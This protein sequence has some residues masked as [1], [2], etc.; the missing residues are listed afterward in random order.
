MKTK[1]TAQGFNTEALK[2]MSDSELADLGLAA[3]FTSLR[4]KLNSDK[5]SDKLTPEEKKKINA[6]RTDWLQEA[7]G[8]ISSQLAWLYSVDGSDRYI[9]ELKFQTVD[10]GVMY[11]ALPVIKP[12]KIGTGESS[13]DYYNKT[14]LKIHFYDKNYTP[15]PDLLHMQDLITGGVINPGHGMTESVGSEDTP[16]DLVANLSTTQIK[17]IIK[18]RKS[19]FT[20]GAEYTNVESF[21]IQSVGTGGS[22]IG[23]ALFLTALNNKD[24]PQLGHGGVG[25]NDDMM[26]I[27]SKADVKCLGMPFLVR[28]QELYV[29]MNSGTTADNMYI[30]TNVKHSIKDNFT[31]TFALTYVGANSI[32]DV[33]K[34]MINAVDLIED[35]L[36]KAQQSSTKASDGEVNKTAVTKEKKK[37]KRTFK[38]RK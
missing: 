20:Y 17:N 19:S 18:R 16:A 7:N 10:L 25:S 23:N 1:K 37:K 38:F 3:E 8:S 24:A 33:R 30:I 21:S 28:G 31:S 32:K 9:G 15:D 4:D 26:I 27:P 34:K 36:P 14:I 22:S 35:S 2:K 11:E 13:A 12:S 29:D 6:K 5:D